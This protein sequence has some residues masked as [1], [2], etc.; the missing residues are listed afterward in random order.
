MNRVCKLVLCTAASVVL[1]AAAHAQGLKE[2]DTVGKDLHV[3]DGLIC[4]TAEQAKKF[5]ATHE[6]AFDG[7]DAGAIN[8]SSLDQDKNECLV[9]GIAFIPG[10]Q[11]DRVR[12]KEQTFAVQEILI[13][14]IA[15]PYGMQKITPDLAYTIVKVDEEGA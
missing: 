2:H 5:F 15:T 9:V 11:L 8:S 10:K 6:D 1:A 4:G 7:P 12:H 13:V 3:S 14:A